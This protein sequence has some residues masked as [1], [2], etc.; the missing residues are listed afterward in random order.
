MS[1]FLS[2]VAL[3]VATVSTVALAPSAALADDHHEAHG[4]SVKSYD[5]THHDVVLV[6]DGHDVDLH[7]EHCVVHGE[8]AAGKTVDVKYAGDQAQEITVH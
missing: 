4:V 6:I 5:A 2:V 1:R 7:T 8:L 3:A